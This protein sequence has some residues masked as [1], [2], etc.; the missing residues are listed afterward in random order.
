MKLFSKINIISIFA[1]V[2]LVSC[3]GG[4]DDFSF[5][6]TEVSSILEANVPDTMKVGETYKLEVTYQKNSNCHR[7]SNFD[8]ANQGDSIYFVRALTIFSES[9]NCVFDPEEVL[10]EI[11]YTNALE[12]DFKFRF[13]KDIDSLG[14]FTFLDKHVVVDGEVND[15]Q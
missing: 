8:V 13:L 2:L 4:D 7:F 12:S 11:N 5:Q 15:E 1:S 10:K 9:T 3:I 6:V 14:E